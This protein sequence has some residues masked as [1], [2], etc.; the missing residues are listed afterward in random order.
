MATKM[1]WLC[2]AAL[3]PA[4]ASAQFDFGGGASTDKPW[5]QG[6][7][8]NSKT[9]VK[10]DFHSGAS[11]DSII[12][13][14]E[15]QSGI[16]IVKD[17]AL[18]GNTAMTSARPVPLTDAFQIL[19]TTLNLKG[20]NLS[21]QG[22]LLVIKSNGGGAR[23]GANGGPQTFDPTQFP[24]NNNDNTE[25]KV[26]PIKWANASAV[27]KV[28]NDVYTPT[29]TGFGG[30]QFG[31]NRGG[32]NPGGNR[33]QGGAFQFGGNNRNQPQVRASSDDFT[34]S[35]IVNA[36]PSDQIQ[37][38]ALIGDLDKNTD[39]P[40]H[41]QVF[42]L[43]Y[44][45]ASDA[46]S[47]IQ[48]VLTANVPRGRAGATSSQTSGPGA[49]FNA[50]RGQTA[51]AGQVVTDTR[52]NSIIVTADDE[53]MAIVTSVVDKIDTP[54]VVQSTT[55][56]YPLAN[57][58]AESV[59]NILQ[60]AFGQR[61]GVTAPNSTQMNQF[62]GPISAESGR[63]TSVSNSV[64]QS[65][66]PTTGLGGSI[67]YDPSA[68]FA[69]E[70]TQ[71][72]QLAL[73]AAGQTYNPFPSIAQQASMRSQGQSY[74]PIQ[75]ADPNAQSGELMTNIG[76]SQGFG[77]GGGNLFRAFAGGQNGSSTSSQ[78]YGTS[79]GPNGQV[80]PTLDPTGQVTAI[81]DMNTNSVIIVTTPE[82]QD[83][84]KAMLKQLDRIPQQ[85]V[86]E[87][88]ICEATLDASNKLGVEWSY[89]H[90]LS[91]LTG[92]NTAQGTVGQNFGVQSGVQGGTSLPGFTYT[93]TG[94]SLTA[95]L[96]A[97]ATDT[98][99]QVLSTPRIMTT[100]NVQAQINVSQSIPYVTSVQTDAAGNPTYS[101]NFLN[102]GVILT[103]QPRI[104]SNG[105]VTLDV[106]QTANE[107]QG[108]QSIGNTEAPIVN[109]REAQST[110]SVKDG[111]TVILGGII[112]KQVTATVNKVPL[113]GDIPILGQ[114]FRSTSKDTTRTEL[115][116]FMTPHVVQT[117]ED[118]G[119]VT[120]DSIKELTPD[121][122]KGVLDEIKKQGGPV[123]PGST[124]P[125]PTGGTGPSNKGNG[126]S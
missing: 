11:W 98:K 78:T 14:F 103:I 5:E 93:V 110:V 22:N 23:P 95:Y 61:P 13:F 116:V 106:D 41:T 38:K 69:M 15:A 120:G 73:K 2:L 4:I 60:T 74:L 50:L 20:Y 89:A 54:V 25:L 83:I 82:N 47:V 65:T 113:L 86:I 58:R 37:V 10:L 7:K 107:L 57:A 44:A 30:I 117:P 9:R 121:S 79:R 18:T 45:A 90:S 70:P 49:F 122:K 67:N 35:V 101:Y 36:P 71:G 97:L 87:T 75:L 91:G 43:K 123:P 27:A 109:Q 39:L 125:A 51:G 32:F 112:Q 6:F 102:V 48:N 33:F 111:E 52:T 34:N 53:D 16:T 64:N 68:G 29:N 76:V 114:L 126:G 3:V 85:V 84:I 46:S 81:P 119:K 88:V 66:R 72:E 96:S 8:L 12:N 62:N 108:Y 56:V 124:G 26:Y 21:K 40:V 94:K 28:L 42:H 77:G 104:L 80:V 24:N 115:L 31:G 63:S 118:A 19:S 105:Y 55:F 99:F 1:R 59:A 17:P 100:N 92:D